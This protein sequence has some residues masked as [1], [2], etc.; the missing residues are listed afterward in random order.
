MKKTF[1][2]ILILLFVITL[3]L[4]ACTPKDP[5][6]DDEKDDALLQIYL[7]S[8]SSD[9]NNAVHKYNREVA[10]GNIDGRK[11]EITEFELEEIESMYDTISSE[12]MAGKV[13]CPA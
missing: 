11:I 7:I 12:M 3:I 4:G 9:E 1:P 6:I 13:T 8:W 2:T 5:Y 10:E